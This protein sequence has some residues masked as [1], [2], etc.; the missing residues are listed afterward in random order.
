MCR[1][2]RLVQ[3]YGEQFVEIVTGGWI[4]CPTCKCTHAPGI[5]YLFEEDKNE[6]VH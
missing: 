5:D 6:E 2:E 1:K 4:V 3:K